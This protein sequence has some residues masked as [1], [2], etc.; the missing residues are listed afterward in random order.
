MKLGKCIC[1]KN[2]MIYKGYSWCA[3]HAKKVALNDKVIC[4]YYLND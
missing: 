4:A 2:I 3:A 1:C